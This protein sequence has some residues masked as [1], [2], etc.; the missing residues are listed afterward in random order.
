MSLLLHKKFTL[1]DFGEIKV[2]LHTSVPTAT[3]LSVH[4]FSH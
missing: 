4:C 3:V 1:P 2:Y